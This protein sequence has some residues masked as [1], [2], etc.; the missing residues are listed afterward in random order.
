MNIFKEIGITGFIDIAFMS[1]IIYSIFIWFKKTKAAFVLTGILIIACVYLF[2]REFNLVLTATVFRGFFAVILVAVVV[3]FQEELKHFFEQVAVW[4]LNRGGQKRKPA[5]DIPA[6]V[7]ILVPT[8]GDLSKEKIGVL[9]LIPGK[10][11]VIRHLH[12]GVELDG[13]V[14]E[15]LLK[16]LFDGLSRMYIP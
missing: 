4:S 10:D 5:R 13:A 6:E 1:L 14:S 9:I 12:G 11:M 7:P 8:V 15:A 3:I 16:S 2:A